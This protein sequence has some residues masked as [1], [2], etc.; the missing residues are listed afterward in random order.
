MEENTSAS[1]VIKGMT[2]EELRRRR[3]LLEAEAAI[4]ELRLTEC[5]RQITRPVSVARS[6][7]SMAFGRLLNG[8]TVIDGLKYGFRSVKWL[9]RL[10]KRFF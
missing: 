7:S 8:F 2:F 6:V 9:S 5:I 4:E 10:M 1:P 3:R